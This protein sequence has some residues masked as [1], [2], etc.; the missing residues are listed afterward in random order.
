[1]GIEEL[2]RY[3][4]LYENFSMEMLYELK[5]FMLDFGEN[6]SNGYPYIFSI[7]AGV[8]SRLIEELHNC[9]YGS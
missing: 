6:C 8:F 9:S 4:I 3:P 5:H 1:M 2:V 7:L